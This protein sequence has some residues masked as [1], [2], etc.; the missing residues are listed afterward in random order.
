MRIK[1]SMITP[2]FFSG[3]KGVRPRTPAPPK[4]ATAQGQVALTRNV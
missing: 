4:S 1:N 3:A 2:Q